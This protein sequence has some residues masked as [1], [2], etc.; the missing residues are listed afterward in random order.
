MTR[1]LERPQVAAAMPSLHAGAALMVALF[2]WP[3]VGTVTRGAL[4]T[5]AVA[6]AVTLAYTGEHYV[7]DIAAGWLVA[8]VATAAARAT[9][10]PFQGPDREDP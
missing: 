6:M 8:V 5:Y 9:M 7:V 10:G 2:V 4:A 3:S 1:E